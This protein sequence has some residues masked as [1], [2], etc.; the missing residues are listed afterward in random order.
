MAQKCEGKEYRA[1]PHAGSWYPGTEKELRE[2]ITGYLDKA[3]A[4]VPGEIVGLISP[5]AGYMYSG[6]VAAHAY[7]LVEGW[8]CDD[9]IVIGPSHRHAFYGASV[10][11]F[12]GRQ[13]PLGKIDFD[14]EIARRLIAAEK[15]ITYESDAHAVEHSV[16]IQMPFIQ[17]T[18]RKF[19]AIEIIM[20]T[21]DYKT[22]EMLSKAIAKATK[23]RTVLIVASSDLSHYQS[24]KRA[25]ALDKLVVDAVAKFDPELLHE[26][27]SSRSCDACGGGPMITAMLVAR[28][29]GADK[30]KPLLYATSGDITGDHTQVVGYMAAAL[31]KEKKVKVGVDLGFSDDE[32]ETLREI[33]RT[34]IENVVRGKPVPKPKKITKKLQEPYGIFV[35]I[36][37]HGDLRGCIGRYIGDHPVYELCGQM[38]QAAALQDPRFPPVTADE[39]EDLEIEISVLTPMQPVR[40]KS[41]IVIGRDGLYIQKGIHGGLLLPQVPVEQGW[42]VDEFL[43]HTCYKAGLP[44]DSLRSKDIE[45]YRFSAEVF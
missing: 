2:T 3:G 36:K 16:E 1:S 9:V 14:I 12:P 41:E 17:F 4:T 28:E 35:T 42:D 32:K 20:G 11:T 21:Q 19:K 39:L 37:K 29:L 8:E 27:L 15:D 25:E 5:H 31:Y 23:G 38:A 33:A 45:V 13:T 22:C 40:D 44:V 10:D 34:S 26:R 6:P 18:V 43:V 30:A 24:Q 7:K